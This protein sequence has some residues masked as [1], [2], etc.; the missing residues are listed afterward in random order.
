MATHIHSDPQPDTQHRPLDIFHLIKINGVHE[1]DAIAISAPG[2]RPLTYG[3]LC[4]HLDDVIRTLNTMGVGRQDRIAIILPNGPEMATA[5]LTVAAGA[6]S[7]PL[8]PDYGPKESRFYLSDLKAKA[9]IVQAG[10]DSPAR[11][12]ARE[13]PRLRISGARPDLKMWLSFF[14]RRGRHRGPRSSL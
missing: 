5:F 11:Q 7:A 12:V 14:I 8:N 13:R 1:P 6:T 2:R 4:D 9:L 10:V 3:G